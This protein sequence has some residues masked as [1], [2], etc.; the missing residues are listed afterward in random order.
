MS[1]DLNISRIRTDDET[2][3]Q[4]AAGKDLTDHP[5]PVIRGLALNR[6]VRRQ[7]AYSFFESQMTT[8][9]ARMPD[10]WGYVSIVCFLLAVVGFGA[11]VIMAVWMAP[12][13]GW[14][15]TVSVIANALLVTAVAIGM[16]AK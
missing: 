15:L 14:P 16:F 6:N 2:L 11:S 9:A 13:Y 8:D 3:D 12:A 7:D 4:L 5:D 10:R 1:D